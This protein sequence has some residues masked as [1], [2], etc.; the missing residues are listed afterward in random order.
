MKEIK[1]RLISR[2]TETKEQII[3]N[4][5]NLLEEHMNQL[6]EATY[7][8]FIYDNKKDGGKYI[9]KKGIL[10]RKNLL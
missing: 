1:K 4:K 9:T 8:Y 2:K 7:T 3:S 10:K 5:I 6:Q